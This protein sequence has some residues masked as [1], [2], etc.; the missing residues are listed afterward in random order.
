MQ[1]IFLSSD[2]QAEEKPRHVR[3]VMTGIAAQAQVTSTL[4]VFIKKNKQAYF[5]YSL[6][7]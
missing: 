5:N 4:S 7:C 2:V 3:D 6:G 1:T